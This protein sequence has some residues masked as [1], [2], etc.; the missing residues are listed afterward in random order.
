[1]RAT[2]V[3]ERDDTC[4][5]GVVSLLH[6]G[7]IIPR[8]AVLLLVEALRIR[9]RTSPLGV[10]RV[11]ATGDVEEQRFALYSLVDGRFRFERVVG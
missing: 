6:V 4:R 10:L 9:E 3:Y 7:S 1:M 2:D 8:K 5:G 11:R